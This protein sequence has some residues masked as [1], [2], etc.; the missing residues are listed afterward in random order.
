MLEEMAKTIIPK[1]LIN[2]TLS[3]PSNVSISFKTLCKFIPLNQY[4]AAPLV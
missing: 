4:A 2:H 3:V 1:S